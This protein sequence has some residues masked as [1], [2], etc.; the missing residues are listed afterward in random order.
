MQYGKSK[1]WP[2]GADAA[3]YSLER[4]N[5]AAFP[6]DPLSWRESPSVR[7]PGRANSGNLPPRVWA[8]GDRTHFT[9][10][11][12]TLRGAVADDRW[13]GNGPN[14][15]WT[16]LSGPAAAEFSALALESVNVRFPVA[17]QYVVRLLASDGTQFSS[18]TTTITVID[19]PF[20]AWRTASF[21]AAELADETISHPLADPDGDLRPNLGEYIFATPPKAPGLSTPL[22][23]ALSPDRLQ[24]T[25]VQRAQL[26]DVVITPE[27]ADRVEGPWFS[28]WEFFDRTETPI[29]GNVEIT[30][31]EKLPV[32][33]RNRGFIRLRYL[34]R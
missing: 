31:R 26:S 29:D 5:P 12:G 33:S 30:I 17:G 21:D 22:S 8:G 19:R 16:Q 28:G 6:N 32:A 10:R 9:G 1:P 18:D 23:L 34:L 20:D 3:G 27:R 25:W 11:E 7:T 2:A 14:S 24:V 4:I 13:S 15:S